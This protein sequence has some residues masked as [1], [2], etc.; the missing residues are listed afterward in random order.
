MQ[1]FRMRSI[2]NDPLS[3]IRSPGSVLVILVTLTVSA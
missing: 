2:D 1:R 3:A